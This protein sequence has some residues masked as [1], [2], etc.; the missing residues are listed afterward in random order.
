MDPPRP[1][2]ALSYP[3]TLRGVLDDGERAHLT[4]F[5][6]ERVRG[7]RSSLTYYHLLRHLASEQ[8]EAGWRI[9]QRVAE[10]VRVELGEG[11][12]LLNDFFSLRTP[13]LR[14]FPSWHQDGEFWIGDDGSSA[15]AC[16][17]FNLWILLDHVGMNYSFDV[18]EVE[19][20]AWA[21][22]D[23]YARQYGL[24][25]GRLAP[26]R[27]LF[28]PGEFATL[29]RKGSNSLRGFF[30]PGEQRVSRLESTNVPLES[31]DALLLRQVCTVHLNHLN[32][33]G[34]GGGASLSAID[35]YVWVERGQGQ[36]LCYLSLVQDLP[37]TLHRP[38]T[39]ALAL[40]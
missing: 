6:F 36:G 34:G 15:D 38:I 11:F 14:L 26:P 8:D 39:N 3:R 13:G 23:L 7:G 17:G 32:T 37:P 18:L 16:T 31:G 2:T 5:F 1:C 35:N 10:R 27:P 24:S 12:T 22:D 4:K 40:P 9:V 33:R 25:D 29:S 20:N 30:K 28:S 21:Y 19:R